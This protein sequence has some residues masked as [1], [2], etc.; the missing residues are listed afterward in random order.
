MNHPQAPAIFTKV[1]DFLEFIRVK[2]YQMEMKKERIFK[3]VE[4]EKI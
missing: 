4:N 2:V 3:C 1:I